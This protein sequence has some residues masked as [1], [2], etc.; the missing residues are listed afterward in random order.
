MIFAVYVLTEKVVHIVSII[1][2]YALAVLAKIT[3]TWYDDA[4]SNGRTLSPYVH[5]IVV[6]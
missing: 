5:G 1:R 6:N 4:V 3:L 2:K